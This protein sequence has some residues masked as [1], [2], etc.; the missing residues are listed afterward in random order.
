MAGGFLFRNGGPAAC[1]LVGRP[2]MAL[3]G[4]DG[5]RLPVR[6]VATDQPP[7]PIVL[8]ANVALPADGMESPVG[9]GSVFLVWSNWCGG[10]PKQPLELRMTGPDGGTLAV[11]MDQTSLPRCDERQAPSTI[12]VGP[13][14]ATTGH[15]PTDPPAIPAESLR[16]TLDVPDHA[17]AGQVLSYVANLANPTGGPISLEPCFTFM[18][19]LNTHGGPVV[20]EHVLACESVPMIAAGASVGFRMELAVPDSFPAD[21]DAALVWSLDPFGD[22]GFAPRAPEAKVPMPVVAP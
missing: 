17:V 16:L 15:D 5:R 13:F 20:V 3:V 19:R 21:P 11:P 12:S 7:V 9:L 1:A 14:A 10:A 22:Q 6:D 4:G 2:S 8:M 18:E